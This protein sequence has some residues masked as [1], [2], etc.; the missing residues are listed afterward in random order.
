[1]SLFPAS[2]HSDCISFECIH[3]HRSFYC[4]G[5]RLVRPRPKHRTKKNRDFVLHLN[6]PVKSV[7]QE[8]VLEAPVIKEAVNNKAAT[9]DGAA[10]GLISPR[11]ERCE[12][13]G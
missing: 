10:V 8:N 4:F 1:M 9:C 13:P 3:A 6:H 11:V 2:A 12:T 5:E 7:L